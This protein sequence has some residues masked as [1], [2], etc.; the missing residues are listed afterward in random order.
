MLFFILKEPHC[1]LQL[2]GPEARRAISGHSECQVL[3]MT[4]RAEVIT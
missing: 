4:H 1:Q 3:V 2:Q